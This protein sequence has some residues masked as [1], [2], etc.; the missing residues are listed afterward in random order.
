M[1]HPNY[2]NKRRTIAII[3]DSLCQFKFFESTYVMLSLILFSPVGAVLPLAVN[4]RTPCQ[5]LTLL[6]ILFGVLL[7]FH[8]LYNQYWIHKY[9]S[10]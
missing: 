9:L 10:N 2:D 6:T 4:Q 5:I 8:S 7:W 1:N 3:R